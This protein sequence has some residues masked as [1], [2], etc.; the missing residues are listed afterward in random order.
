MQRENLAQAG[1][2]DKKAPEIGCFRS[3]IDENECLQN[4]FCAYNSCSISP[5]EQKSP[6][7]KL[8]KKATRWPKNDF[9]DKNH[10]Y[11]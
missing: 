3:E 7:H 2:Q 11:S 8:R 1:K 9:L 4:G 10:D 6:L 5:Q